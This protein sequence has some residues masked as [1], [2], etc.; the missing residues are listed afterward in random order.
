MANIATID[1]DAGGGP[2]GSN[3]HLSVTSSCLFQPE[4]VIDRSWVCMATNCITRT[5]DM[6]LY[7]RSPISSFV[8]TG[9]VQAASK[10]NDRTARL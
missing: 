7:L 8:V 10:T 5:G 9:S 1:S 4:I 3:S 2:R 6:G